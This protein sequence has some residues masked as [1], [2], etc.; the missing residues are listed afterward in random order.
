MPQLPKSGSRRARSR[1][2]AKP[3]TRC[4]APAEKTRRSNAD[5]A[6]GAAARQA[7]TSTRKQRSSGDSAS[8][9]SAGGA[10]GPTKS[11]DAPHSVSTATSSVGQSMAARTFARPLASATHV[12]AGAASS[13]GHCSSTGGFEKA[14]HLAVSPWSSYSPALKLGRR[15][16]SESSSGARYLFRKFFAHLEWPCS[17]HAS[18]RRSAATTSTHN[19]SVSA[20]A[21]GAVTM[22][23]AAWRS[24]EAARHAAARARRE[25]TTALG[26][27]TRPM[28]RAT[29]ASFFRDASGLASEASSAASKRGFRS[30]GAAPKCAPRRSASVSSRCAVS[31]ASSTTRSTAARTF[32]GSGASRPRLWRRRSWP[33]RRPAPRR[34]ARGTGMSRRFATRASDSTTSAAPRSAPCAASVAASRSAHRCASLKAARLR[35][36]F[37]CGD[38]WPWSS[39]SNSSADSTAAV[40]ATTT[41]SSPRGKPTITSSPSSSA[42]SLGRA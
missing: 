2:N 21:T 20:P 6:A 10:Q 27:P 38:G 12:A 42:P 14:S 15:G 25:D 31:I 28:I 33:S 35:P 7:V 30:K 18:T 3:R 24:P 41:S 29:V 26:R 9:I 37:T 36:F 19:S 40:R 17:K 34:N 5:R 8:C 23:S 32:S 11:A 13:S 16:A 39:I 1:E 22:S 4:G